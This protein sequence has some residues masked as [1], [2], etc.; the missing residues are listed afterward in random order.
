VLLAEQAP[1]GRIMR[2]GLSLPMSK[3]RQ[4]VSLK[5]SL[6]G[7][8]QKNGCWPV[9]AE[10][11]DQ[12]ESVTLTDGRRRWSEA[13]DYLACGFGLVPNWE[14]AALL[15][16]DVGGGRVQVDPMQATSVADVYCAG[17]PTGI[18]GVDLAL[19][20]GQI[21]GLAAAGR[22]GEA[23]P[24]FPQREKAR[25]FVAA[26]DRAF[27]LRDELFRLATPETIVCRCEDISH[28][29]LR[30]FSSW[31]E[32]KLQARCGMGP[33]QGRICGPATKLLYGWSCESVRPPVLPVSL[34]SLAETYP[35]SREE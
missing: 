2:F 18:G 22:T 29:T 34:S 26:L 23:R 27:A 32:A 14:L 11:R 16:C 35:A 20:E 4:A 31:R 12:I 19:L 28:E 25:K 30:S 10:G 21:A 17:E 6:L 1:I 8:P 33:C 15:G 13:C 5:R 24:L 9:S 7:I 3:V